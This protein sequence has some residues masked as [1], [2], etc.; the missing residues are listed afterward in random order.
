[1]KTAKVTKSETTKDIAKTLLYFAFTIIIT[2]LLSTLFVVGFAKVLHFF[3]IVTLYTN[4][5]AM[6]I[7][8]G[9]IC[10]AVFKLIKAGENDILNALERYEHSKN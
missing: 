3:G 5:L 6:G 9:L 7:S 1:M 8:I 4:D 10:S 2:L